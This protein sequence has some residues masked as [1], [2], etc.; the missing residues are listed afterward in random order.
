[1]SKYSLVYFLL[2][3]AGAYSSEITHSVMPVIEQA[4][5]HPSSKY[6]LS[7][8]KEINKVL[9]KK[10]DKIRIVTYNILFD[11]FDD[12]L[13][14]KSN[15]WKARLPLVISSIQNMNPDVFCVQEAYA[16]QLKDIESALENSFNCYV[17]PSTSGELNA[18]FYKRDRFE[19]NPSGSNSLQ[20][21][22]NPADEVIVAG[23]AGFLG[24]E[25]E[26]GR[27]LTVARLKDKQTE[28]E[29]VVMNTHLTYHRINSREDQADYISTM[30]AQQSVPA[31]VVGDM[32]TFPNRPD[33]QNFQFY[34]G[35]YICHIFQKNLKDTREASLLGHAGPLCTSIRDFATR[36]NRPFE[37]NEFAGVIA[38]HIFVSPE[39]AVL[40]NA[41][42][43]CLV[44][45][46][47]PSDHFPVVA[48][49]LLP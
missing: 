12:Q 13:A 4:E 10:K 16:N 32:N 28:K 35:D 47:F 27:Q 37:E 43:P 40:I 42:E 48:D 41:V 6:S 22:L 24:P 1:M 39:I 45:H 3:T 29:F 18:I 25:L 36:N 49:I 8:Q 31:I 14:D 38:D 20:L 44:D 2:I 33:R 21:P 17:G 23:I 5:T 7:H 26:P 15:T 19:I 30:A 9:E 11:L 34:D 46:H